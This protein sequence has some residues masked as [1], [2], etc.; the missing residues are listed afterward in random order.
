M[1]FMTDGEIDLKLFY[2][3]VDKENYP[4]S[5]FYNIFLSNTNTLIGSIALHIGAVKGKEHLGEIEYQIDDAYQGHH[6]AKKACL[7]LKEV[8]K[9]YQKNSVTIA[10]DKNNVA[11]LKTIE[12]LQGKLLKTVTMENEEKNIYEVTLERGNIK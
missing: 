6:Y 2:K 7:L 12:A 4:P 3:V 9:I 5:Y 10:C 8:L 11:S 1:E